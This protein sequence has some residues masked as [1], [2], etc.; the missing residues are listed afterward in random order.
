M[1][2]LGVTSAAGERR[3]GGLIIAGSYV[4]KT[5]VQL[6]ALTQRLKA[7]L[8][9]V[10][11]KVP[12][13]IASEDAAESIVRAA[14]QAVSIKLYAG[15]DV[16]VMT[17][18]ELIKGDDGLSSLNIGSKVANS[19]MQLLELVDVHPRYIIAKG[20]ITSSD[21]ATKG[22]KMKRARVLGQVA[23][24]VPL[25]RCDEET[26]R[27]RGVPVRRFPWKCRQ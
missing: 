7:K 9:V 5:T 10:E 13:L 19:L 14:A 26:S 23:P 18:R 20:G 12:D 2:D 21:T 24:G 1:K 6:E 16:L 17:S 15:H 22:L 8:Q 25:W 4:P 11:L 3:P 27:H